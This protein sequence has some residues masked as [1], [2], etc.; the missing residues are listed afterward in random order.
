MRVCVIYD[1]LYPWTVGGAERWLRTLSEALAAEGHEVT[2]LTRRQWPAQSPPQIPGV[3]VIA[4]S[5]D[6]PLYGP[7]GARTLGEPIRF[8]WGV[9]RHL[10]THRK[11]YDVVHTAAFPYFSLL[12]AAVALK[13]S[14]TLLITDWYEVWSRTYWRRYLGRAS[15]FVGWVVQRLCMRVRQH[16][17]VFSDLHARRL[18]AEGFRGKVTKLTGLYSRDEA[19]TGTHDGAYPSEP[20]VVFAGRHVAEKQ[21]TAIPAAIAAARNRL[22]GVRALILGDGPEWPMLR[23]AITAAG[24]ADIV[25]APGFVPREQMLEALGRAACL[26]LPSL[27]EGYGL[28]VVEAAALGTPS[29]VIRAEDNAAAELVRDGVNGFVAPSSAP[30]VLADA[31]LAVHQAGAALRESTAGWFVQNAKQLSMD[32]SLRHVLRTYQAINNP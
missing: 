15:G 11:T 10:F 8:G 31:V 26:L 18:I 4:V 12:A 17:F 28:I 23:N 22:P 29:I 20:L 32:A 19:L 21:V 6:E 14:R 27:R 1:C 3:S 5:R 16:A 30:E 2:Y 24:V 25:D 9:L 13:G 7:G